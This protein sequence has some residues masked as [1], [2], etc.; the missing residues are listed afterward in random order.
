M[1][2]NCELM[3][4]DEVHA[5]LLYLIRQMNDISEKTGIPYFAHAGTLIGAAR[6][7]GFIPW[8]DDVDLIIE[9]K[10]YDAFVE[11]CDKYLPEQ[12]VLRTRERDPYFC[13]EYIKMCFRDEVCEY[14]ELALDI[15]VLDET[16]PD[17][18][19][20]RAI[21]NRIIRD[22]RPIKLYKSSRM[23]D[24]MEPYVPHNKL[25]HMWLAIAGLLPLRWLTDLQT[26]AMTAEK[27]STDWYVDWGSTSGYVRATRPKYFFEAT[28]KMPFEN[29]YIYTSVH[30]VEMLD[31]VYKKFPWRE[32]PP[33]EKRK[34]H[35]VP[36]IN[37]KH[38]D[39]AEIRHEMEI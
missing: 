33:P 31:Y 2:A 16:D 4:I 29:T 10:Y 9:R 28:K 34:S 36:Y 6:H 35:S 17:R 24:Y 15:F 26:K 11:A 22:V 20:F 25:K 19:L 8:D 18:K 1:N 32:I 21:Q 27:K 37:N 38:L 14:S 13:E 7:Q 3:P 23:A 30:E 39:I 5:L 12:V